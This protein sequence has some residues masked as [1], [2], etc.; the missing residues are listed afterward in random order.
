MRIKPFH[1]VHLIFRK[2]YIRY[3]RPS[4]FKTAQRTRKGECKACGSCCRINTSCPFLDVTGKCTIYH[5]QPYFCRV[6]PIDK[7]DIQLNGV[8]N[9]CGYYWNTPL[10]TDKTPKNQRID[11][12]SQQFYNLSFQGAES[13]FCATDGVLPNVLWIPDE[14]IINENHESGSTPCLIA[15][16]AVNPEKKLRL[17]SHNRDTGLIVNFNS[18]LL[19]R[20]I[21]SERYVGLMK[22][23]FEFKLPFN[24][25]KIPGSLKQLGRRLRTKTLYHE[26]R[27]DF[28]EKKFPF[29]VDWLNCISTPAYENKNQGIYPSGAKAAIVISHDVDSNWIFKNTGL[30]QNI[31]AL[32]KEFGHRSTWFCVPQNSTCRDSVS[33]LEYIRN[34]QC[35]VACHGYNHDG[36]LP[37][38][39]GR[40]FEQRFELIK[41]F[42]VRWQV[43]GF[44]SEWL[45]R[46]PFFIDKIGEIFTYDSS[47]P[48]SS[49]LFSRDTRNGSGTCRPYKIGKS[50]IEIPVS[51]PMDSDVYPPSAGNSI[52]NDEYKNLVKQ[53]YH[54]GG[55]I[56][57]T[58][59]TEPYLLANDQKLTKFR[60]FLQWLERFNQVH[61]AT[62]GEIAGLTW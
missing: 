16:S 37:L 22:I 12:L 53:I 21:Q 54:F 13:L 61:K 32:E 43:K 18:K 51:L 23:P 47:V 46:N 1:L 4:V 20:Q 28:P 49:A 59:H 27:I 7:R 5:K 3:F 14:N 17:L 48:S 62:A 52:F 24:Y 50:L 56:H 33:G 29:I 34:Q 26:P 45:W 35:E 57:I 58:L 31:I 11:N 40:K 6:F 44:R 41:D 55:V 39:T 2:R 10:P 36:K 8:S 30:L 38:K 9:T 19:A 42:S 25:S 15:T 60:D